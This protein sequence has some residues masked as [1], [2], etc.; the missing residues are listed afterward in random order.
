MRDESILLV[1]F[2]LLFFVYINIYSNIFVFIMNYFSEFLGVTFSFL[3]FLIV[4]NNWGVLKNNLYK[5]NNTNIVQTIKNNPVVVKCQ[6]V[7]Y[8]IGTLI[9]RFFYPKKKAKIQRQK[10]EKNPIS[11]DKVRKIVKL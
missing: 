8:I 3:L 4:Y 9:Y 2:L 7:C 5:L 6:L 11:K 1:T 10:I